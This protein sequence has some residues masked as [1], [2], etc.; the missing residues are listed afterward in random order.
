[1]PF[2]TILKILLP[3]CLFL[4]AG[5][6]CLI[7]FL[8]GIATHWVRSAIDPLPGNLPLDFT[9][10]HVGVNWTRISDISLG[11]DV[12]LD[13]MRFDYHMDKKNIVTVDRCIISGLSLHVYLDE[14][15]NVRCCGFS[16]PQEK[17]APSSAPAFDRTALES[18][19]R[20][21]P[22]QV[23][24]KNSTIVIDNGKDRF[25][26][27]VAAEGRLDRETLLGN[28]KLSI[29]PM[30]Q[31]ILLGATGHILDGPV[32]MKMSGDHIYPELL[33]AMMPGGGQGLGTCYG[34][35]NFAI[36]TKD[37][38]TFHVE[39]NDL[40]LAPDPHFKFNFPK[41]DGTL[42]AD[43]AVL[44][45]KANG[46]VQIR[47]PGMDL[48]LFDF[49]ISSR[50]TSETMDQF[51]LTVQNKP[52]NAWLIKPEIMALPLSAA[53]SFQKIKLFAPRFKLRV[54]GDLDHQTGTLAFSGKSLESSGSGKAKLDAAG[55]DLNIQFNGNLKG[56][57]TLAYGK[58]NARIDKLAFKQNNSGVR[59]KGV[60]VELPGTYPFKGTK[61]FG[62]VGASQIIVQD[63]VRAA[64]SAKVAQASDFAV[65]IAGTVT[66]TQVPGLVVD[67]S[68][69]AGLEAS[70]APFAKG[71]MHTNQFSI[72]QDTVI[73]FV[74][75]ISGIYDF[76]FDISAQSDFSYA[77]Q[78]IKS[79]ADIQ[80]SNGTINFVESGFTVSGI[81]TDMHFNDL[82]VPE[83]LPGQYLSIDRF[84]AGR[85]NCNNARIRFSLEDGR[86]INVENLKFNW[87]NGIV[88]T[89][90]FRLPSD[91]GI[92]DITLYCDRLGMEDLFYQLDAFD[93]EGDG[94]LSGRIPVVVKNTKIGFDDGFLF[95]T[96]GQGGRIFI[97]NLD[98]MLVGIPKNTREY[99]QLDLAGEALK[100]FEYKWVTLKLNSHGETLAVN[101]QLDG[102]PLS[103][104]PF[105][106]NRNLNS[107][108]RIG[109]K[110]PGS[111]FQG[112]KLNVNLNLP[113]NQVI[114]FG[115]NLKRIINP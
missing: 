82:M 29:F 14:K 112:I 11:E 107:F 83:T 9:I 56:H 7:I 66:S 106:Y 74:P 54:S 113:F 103:S 24:L 32:E 46:P 51:S 108:I 93:A 35:V 53:D 41:V 42:T 45:L 88:S 40:D 67:F 36:E 114:Q 57:E 19:I 65:D 20:Y 1:M 87:C 70:M 75:A 22:A 109:A 48:G 61:G 47:S 78:A 64:V 2:K 23:V 43:N 91:D 97:R 76:K 3:G 21:L 80:V 105:E 15:N 98:K 50:I 52:T 110:S 4:V 96:P 26:I 102:K 8:P 81:S 84:D 60:Y 92:I 111:N 25:D 30:N 34:P 38:S 16:I 115:N 18:Y 77:H 17:D 5:I 73:P 12:Q 33:F 62:R 69:R 49:Q 86:F 59:A 31:K 55:L 101:M 85:F 27:P 58:L 28:V 72:S 94:T 79:S 99:A 10:S 89:E 6:L 95:S 37:F 13:T 100:N 63:K 90:A 104:L 68:T 39:L 71:K 44:L